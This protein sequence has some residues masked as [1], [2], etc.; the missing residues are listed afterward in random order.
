MRLLFTRVEKMNWDDF[1]TAADAFQDVF[2]EASDASSIHVDPNAPD[3]AIYADPNPEAVPANVI[4]KRREFVEDDSEASYDGQSDSEY[5]N[6]SDWQNTLEDATAQE[7]LSAILFEACVQAFRSL[8]HIICEKSDV[9]GR[10]TI[11]DLREEFRKF[12]VW[13]DIF[14]TTS[15]QLG[16][17]LS[18]SRNLKEAVF[19]LIAQWARALCKGI[20]NHSSLFRGR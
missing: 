6:V 16:S 15:G 18:T 2:N 14:P 4:S 5:S 13:N 8:F 20:I 12:Y 3:V 10:H 19:S 9:L 11:D 1:L 7:D 17:I